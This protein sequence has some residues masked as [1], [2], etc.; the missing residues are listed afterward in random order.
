MGAAHKRNKITFYCR[1]RHTDDVA[2]RFVTSNIFRRFSSSH[3]NT[4]IRPA[5]YT[6]NNIINLCALRAACF[7]YI[8]RY[9]EPFESSTLYKI[10]Q[11]I[12]AL[13]ISSSSS[14]ATDPQ[15]RIYAHLG[16]ATEF[17]IE[18]YAKLF[19]SL[20]LILEQREIV[21]IQSDI[22]LSSLD[23]PSLLGIVQKCICDF[24]HLKLLIDYNTSI[25]DIYSSFVHYIISTTKSL[26]MLSL[27]GER[28]ENIK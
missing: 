10:C 2:L 15:D 8:L 11:P 7:N 3:Y 16:I 9:R 21:S 14:E 19:R 5:N 27:A 17:S 22:D 13:V 24:N 1:E 28:T 23:R 6:F 12:L 18:N 4:N 26:N 25:E 20:Y